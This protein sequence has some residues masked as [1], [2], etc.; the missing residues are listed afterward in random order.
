MAC[1]LLRPGPLQ[2][3]FTG[4]FLGVKQLPQSITVVQQGRIT[5]CQ[6]YCRHQY[7]YINV[8]APTYGVDVRFASTLLPSSRPLDIP[9]AYN[10]HMSLSM[11]EMAAAIL[12]TQRRH[13]RTS[14]IILSTVFWVRPSCLLSS[15]R[16]GAHLSVDRHDA[17]RMPRPALTKPCLFTNDSLLLY[18]LRTY[19]IYSYYDLKLYSRIM[20]SNYT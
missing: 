12:R 10:F 18:L 19:A 16:E 5:V 8:P 17:W 9:R 7:S 6:L 11:V 13:A 2:D 14:F 20:I 3:F 15:T 1:T 4:R